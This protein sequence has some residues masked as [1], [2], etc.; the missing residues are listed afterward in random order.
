M[1]QPRR[2]NLEFWTRFLPG[3]TITNNGEQIEGSNLP[4]ILSLLDLS[5]LSGAALMTIDR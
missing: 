1:F 4:H 2:R 3:I 5:V